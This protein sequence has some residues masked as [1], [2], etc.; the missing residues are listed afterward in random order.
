M[1]APA[2][3]LRICGKTDSM[4]WQIMCWPRHVVRKTRIASK[5]FCVASP[6]KAE[7]TVA[8]LLHGPASQNASS[9]FVC[10]ACFEC[11]GARQK[12]FNTRLDSNTVRAIDFHEGESVDETALKA[13]ISNTVRAIDFHEGESVDETALKALILEAVGLNTRA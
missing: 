7:K 13:L 2:S 8:A 6:Q 3:G 4:I 9:T 12:L 11:L 10:L 1:Q 5:F